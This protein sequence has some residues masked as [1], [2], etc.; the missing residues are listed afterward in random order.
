METLYS[1]AFDYWGKG[2]Q[3]T[4]SNASPT[5]PSLFPL[6]N[7]G[8]ATNGNNSIGCLATGFTPSSLSFIWTDDSGTVLTDY[9]QYPSVQ[10][11]QAF[12]GVSQLRVNKAD[13][14][15]AKSF[16]CAVK[17]PAGD[18]T[19]DIFKPVL[20]NPA[21]SLTVTL[22]PPS[23]KTLIVKNQAVLECLVTATDQNIVSKAMITWK[24][25]EKAWTEKITPSNGLNNSKGSTLT[26]SEV[27]YKK[28]NT[29]QCFAQSG[30]ISSKSQAYWTN[31]T[32]PK[33]SVHILPDE[34]TNEG[35]MT[36]V[37]LVVSSCECDVYISWKETK[38]SMSS[39]KE[40]ITN[41]PQ[42]TPDGKNLF[43]SFFNITKSKWDSEMMYHCAVAV[44][45]GKAPR[46]HAW[47]EALEDLQNDPGFYL[48][49][50]GNIDENDELSSLWST[51]SSFI[52]LFLLSL[53]YSAVI[54][55][56]KVKQ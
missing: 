47:S 33:V 17:H 20:L 6:M 7:C 2:T 55:L 15:K 41:Q 1:D 12:S 49:C 13:W 48:N 28:H 23:V 21:G 53:T 32:V 30:T 52:I 34:D 56:V 54:S 50:T 22:K 3:V 39:Y 16:T 46:E 44:A 5:A 19:Q 24:V 4:V 29:F 11:G 38:G 14:E 35:D 51:T 37:C 27:D 45:D 9:V 31:I 18:R 40:G 36:L 8:T 10:M 42:K 26:M 43:T 25:D